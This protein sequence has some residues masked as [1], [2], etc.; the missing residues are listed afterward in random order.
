MCQASRE[1]ISGLANAG[2]PWQAAD[3]GASVICLFAGIYAAA[4]PKTPQ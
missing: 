3:Q 2:D 4:A 1:V